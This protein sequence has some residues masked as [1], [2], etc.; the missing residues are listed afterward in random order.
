MATTLNKTFWKRNRGKL[1]R[2]IMRGEFGVKAK[3]L[4]LSMARAKIQCR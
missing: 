3:S 4:L 1:G 2:K